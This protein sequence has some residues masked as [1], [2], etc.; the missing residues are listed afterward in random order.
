MHLCARAGKYIEL[1]IQGAT[2]LAGINSVEEKL[3]KGENDN[4]RVFL[5]NEDCKCTFPGLMPTSPVL[6]LF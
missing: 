6:M 4:L 3:Q 1:D 2:I 5:L